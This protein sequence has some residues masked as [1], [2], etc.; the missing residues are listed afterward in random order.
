MSNYIE[1]VIENCKKN[2]PGEVEFHQTVEEVL[3]SLEP[4]IAKHPEYEE[5]AI[6]ERLVEP[7]RGITFKVTWVDDAGKVQV[8]KGYRYQFNSAIGPYKGGL[9][10]APN[11]YPGIIKFLGFEQ[12]FKNSLTGLP[13]GG[14]KGGANFDPNG[15]SDAEVMRFCQAFITELYRHIGPSTDVPAGDLGVGGREIGYMFG[16]YKKIVNRFEGTL[17]GKGLSWGGLNGRTEATGY[18]IVYYAQCMLEANGESLKDKKVA[19]SGFGNVSWGTAMK[20]NELGAKVITISGPDG[21][22]YDPDGVSGEKVDYM[23]ELRGSG[24]NI[25]APY[26]DKFP[27]ATFYAGKKPWEVEA[28]L[29]IPCATQNEI[30]EDDAKSFVERGV[31]FVCE[32]SNMSSTNE[33]IKIMQDGG[34]IVGPSKA[35]NAGGVA[36]SCIEMG[37]NAGKTV[38]TPDQVHAQLKDIM[39][40]IHKACQEAAEEY[41]FGYNLVAGANIAG[42]LKVADAM[43]AQGIC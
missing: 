41:G 13:I 29:Y 3:H 14:G 32:G 36:C 15:K 38:F 31:K 28:D 24:K 33:A 1:T 39:V 22:I 4:V 7:E 19:I 35:A 27:G 40:G 11:V 17:T 18:G 8:N 43:M 6:L 2:N 42:F 30:R 5:A 10:F 26:A 20:L 12:I 21:Y 25:C 16:Q 9:R 34:I 37:Q 23:L